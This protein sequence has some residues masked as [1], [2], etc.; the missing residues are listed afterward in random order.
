[1]KLIMICYNEAMDDEIDE[2]M[3]QADVK[4]YTKWTKVLGKGTTSEPHLLSH[5]WPKANN[6]MA[7]AVEED[8]AKTIL[9]KVRDMKTKAGT[10]GLK[11]FMWEIDDVT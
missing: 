7:V 5:I 4:G 11:A 3:Q 6:V 2:L 9:E 1:M 8:T 10:I